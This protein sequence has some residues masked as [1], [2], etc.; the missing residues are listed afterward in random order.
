MLKSE[1]TGS[2]TIRIDDEDLERRFREK[3]KGED[4]TPSQVIR[5]M[6]RQYVS[7]R[8]KRQTATA[9]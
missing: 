9:R 8:T 6:I 7:G 2:I 1:P 4:L 5:S 3:A